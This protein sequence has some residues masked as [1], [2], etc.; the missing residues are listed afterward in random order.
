MFRAKLTVDK[1]TLNQY[2]DDVEFIAKYDGSKPEDN[3]Y[4]KATPSA[5][6]KMCITNPELRDK[7]KP[8]QVFYV[9][10]KPV[11]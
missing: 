2:S 8:G 3:S 1:V 9:D 4:A 5:S 10:F 6:L 7:I 11:T